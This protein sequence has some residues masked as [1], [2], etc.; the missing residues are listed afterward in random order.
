MQFVCVC[1]R[2][3][4]S[5]SQSIRSGIH[6][7]LSCDCAIDAVSRSPCR[8]RQR[9]HCRIAHERWLRYLIIL[10]GSSISVMRYVWHHFFFHRIASTLPPRLPDLIRFYMHIFII[11]YYKLHYMRTHTHAHCS[12][13][14][15]LY[16]SQQFMVCSFG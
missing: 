7:S 11:M 14:I 13:F 2:A 4:V 9:C 5:V 3:R 1:V 10:H 16:V 12:S 15:L 6:S 8:H